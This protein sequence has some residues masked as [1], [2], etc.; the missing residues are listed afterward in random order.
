MPVRLASAGALALAIVIA[1]CGGGATP[2]TVPATSG[3]ATT[4]PATVAPATDAPATDVPAT[5]APATDAPATGTPASLDPGASLD[6]SQSDAGI[7]GR[8]TIPNDTRDERSGTHLIIGREGHGFGTDCSYT[9]EGD[10]FI[11]VAY[12][13]DAQNGQIYQMSVSV[14][15]DSMPA[16]D[17]EQRADITNGVAYVDF[18]SESGLGTAYTGATERED[19]TSTID[20]SVADDL[21]FFS[22]EAVTWDDIAFSGQMVCAGAEL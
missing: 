5:D 2:T 8:V 15:T 10:E 9:F 21:I 4:A 12:N 13:D 7:V 22:F 19:G 16:N 20:I 14:P 11:A 1:A 17:G 3:T 6:P 18:R